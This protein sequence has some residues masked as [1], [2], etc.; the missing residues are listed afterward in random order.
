MAMPYPCPHGRCIYCPKGNTAPQSYLDESPAIKRVSGMNHD[1]NKQVRS[2]LEM[3]KGMGHPTSKIELIFIGGTFLAYP[4]EYQEKFVK[5]CFDALNGFEGA[6][7]E[8]AKKAN[9]TASHRCVALCIETR[10]DWALPEHIDSALRFGATRIELGVQMPDDEI[11]RKI[12]RGHTVKHVIEATK[13]LKDAGFKVGYHIMTGLPGSSPEKD[14]ELFTKLFENPDFRP[15]QL[16]I[17]PCQVME[18]TPLAELWKKGEYSAYEEPVLIELLARMKQVIPPYC[19]VMRMMRQFH[20]KNVLA[21]NYKS[22]LR[23]DAKAWLTAR[24][25][26]CSCI[27]CREV[28]FQKGKVKDDVKIN[29]LEYEA[30]NGREF[31]I[32]AVNSDNVC[33]GL[34]RCRIPSNPWRPEITKQ[35]LLVRELHIYGKETELNEEA[36]SVQHRGLGKQLMQKAEEL[37]KANKCSRIAV[38]SGVGVREYYRK[39]G[40]ELEGEYMVKKF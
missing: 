18:G 19:R 22:D 23:E 33:F 7:L 25:L 28:G 4:E 30:S 1:S 27:R 6:T 32:Q 24:G 14:L 10:P 31:F 29:V 36:K 8:E 2:R 5:G 13:Y 11:Y 35:T 37:A 39:L 40:Y 26:K 34:C 9:E 38:I 20:P 12:A 16:K 17:Y 3:F 15:D 21:G